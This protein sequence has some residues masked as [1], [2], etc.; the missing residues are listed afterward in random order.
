MNV[1]SM[2]CMC[3]CSV[4]SDSLGPPW[5]VA[6]QAPLSMELFKQEYWSGLPFPSPRDLLNSGIEP[7]SPVSPALQADSLPAEPLGK[8][9]F[10][11][12][13]YHS[14]NNSLSTKEKNDPL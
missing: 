4:V 12:T 5:T 2:R 10:L 6:H 1:L 8:P 14:I 13:E 9:Y 3:V 11:F 7:I